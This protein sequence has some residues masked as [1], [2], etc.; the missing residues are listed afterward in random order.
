MKSLLVLFTSL[1]TLTATDVPQG[2]DSVDLE[3]LV[4]HWQLDMSPQDQ[5]DDNFAMMN[6]SI[7]VDG[8][9][10]G[11]FYREG[12]EIRNAQ[13]N[14]Q[15]GIIYGSLISGDRSGTYNTTFYYKGGVLHGTTHAVDKNFL[16]VWTAVKV[17]Q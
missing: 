14:T 7:I 11:E 10:T 6:I 9:L 16:A 2:T 4:G 13:T 17:K 3:V 15:L 1:L 12:V 5:T 8:T